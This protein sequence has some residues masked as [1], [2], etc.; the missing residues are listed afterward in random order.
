MRDILLDL[1]A[2]F[3]SAYNN[4]EKS[5]VFR[6]LLS[7]PL[8]L[9]DVSYSK[10]EKKL[11]WTMKR[12]LHLGSIRWDSSVPGDVW[13]SIALTS[14]SCLD[15]LRVLDIDDSGMSDDLLLPILNKCRNSLKELRFRRCYAITAASAA[16]IGE[17]SELEVLHP[18]DAVTSRLSEIAG[19]LP[20]LRECDFSYSYSSSL[21]DEGVTDLAMSCPGLEI[22]DLSSYRSM[23]D[24][25]IVSLVQHSH[26]LKKLR[27]TWN[28]QLTDAAFTGLSEGCWQKMEVLNLDGLRLLSE[29]SFSSLVRACPS[30][31]EVVLSRTNVTDEAVWTLCQLC[32]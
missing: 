10:G 21:T 4:H 18:N 22:L 24:A 30:L 14:C 13:R 11:R 6:S 26:M 29:T 5:E 15:R 23:S 25:A 2:D 27:L 12:R 20:K 32:P 8:S 9:F 1:A 28:D 16:P 19:G 31:V 7:S 17:C 3:D